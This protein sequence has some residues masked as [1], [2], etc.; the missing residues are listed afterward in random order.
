MMHLAYIDIPN[1]A[2]VFSSGFGYLFAV[3]GAFLGVILWR[4][5]QIYGFIKRQLK[6][7]PVETVNEQRRGKPPV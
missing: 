7:I 2:H 6:P 1:T 3:L 4:I 5:K